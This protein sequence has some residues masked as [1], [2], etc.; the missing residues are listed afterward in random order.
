[1]KSRPHRDHQFDRLG[2]RRKSRSGG[3]GIERWRVDTLDVVE[4]KFRDKRQVEPDF[5]AALRQP[6]DVVP[7]R[8][9]L[10]VLHIGEPASETRHPVPVTHSTRLPYKIVDQP[11]KGV[12]ANGPRPVGYEI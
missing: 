2:N 3:P 5:F 8:L 7:T 9:H 4:I 6:R 12:K 1:M 11:L 10:L